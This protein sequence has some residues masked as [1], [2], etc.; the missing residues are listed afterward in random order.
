MCDELYDNYL[1]VA[2][3]FD[4]E[5]FYLCHLEQ[6]LIYT[7]Q[8]FENIIELKSFLF[9]DMKLSTGK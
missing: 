6:Y 1:K 3:E 9:Q 8:S 2:V 7:A 5:G 4:S